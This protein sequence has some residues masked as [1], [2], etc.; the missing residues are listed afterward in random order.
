MAWRAPVA[1]LVA[2]ALVATAGAQANRSPRKLLVLGDSLSSAYNI[3]RERGW[4]A[5]LQARLAER[6]SSYDVVNASIT[7]ETTTGA[8]ARL[9]RVLVEHRPAILLIELGGNDGLQGVPLEVSA[10]NLAAM[11]EAGQSAGATVLLL[12]MELPPNYGPDYTARFRSIY[13]EL[14][15]R[16]DAALLPFLLDGVALEPSLM[17]SDGIHPRAEAQ[18]RLLDNVW[19][20][21]EPLLDALPGDN[22]DG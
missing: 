19:E 13:R 1:V 4:V 5:L 17:Q 2:L 11:I 3:P 15:Q 18:P 8:R 9:E 6:E 16:Y 14:A 22:P 20:Q 12:G 7:G 21:L 10:A